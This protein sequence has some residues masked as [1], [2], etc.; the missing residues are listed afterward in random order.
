MVK[1]WK[2]WIFTALVSGELGSVSGFA[3]ICIYLHVNDDIL[4]EIPVALCVFHCHCLL[5]NY[6]SL[7]TDHTF[8]GFLSRDRFEQLLYI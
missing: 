7:N 2:I 3:C 8:V 5:F 1:T 6:Y 4:V